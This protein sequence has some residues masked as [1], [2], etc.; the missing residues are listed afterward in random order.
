MHKARVW[1]LLRV[2]VYVLELQ[3]R[4][5]VQPEQKKSLRAEFN[6]TDLTFEEGIKNNPKFAECIKT[7]ASIRFFFA[8]VAF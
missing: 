2:V 6:Q 1:R 3:F 7:V 4:F 8:P 5:F